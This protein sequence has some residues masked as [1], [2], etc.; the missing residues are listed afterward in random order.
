MSHEERSEYMGATA[1]TGEMDL[2]RIVCASE[3]RWRRVEE[4]KGVEDVG[5]V[6]GMA[7]WVVGGGEA[8]VE[9]GD[10]AAGQG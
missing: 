3:Q 9:E 4:V 10:G 6:G 2:R 8:V 7:E 5:A 1:V